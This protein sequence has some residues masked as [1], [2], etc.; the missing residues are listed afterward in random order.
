MQTSKTGNTLWSIHDKIHF[1]H[2]HSMPYPSIKHKTEVGSGQSINCLENGI[3]FFLQAKIVH[4][5]YSFF[6][7]S[8]HVELVLSSFYQFWVSTIYLPNSFQTLVLVSFQ[9]INFV[10]RIEPQFWIIFHGDWVFFLETADA[11]IFLQPIHQSESLK[12]DDVA[13]QLAVKERNS[14]IKVES[15]SGF[16]RLLPKIKSTALSL[17]LKP[18]EA[19]EVRNFPD[20]E[21]RLE[22]TD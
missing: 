13:S 16:A 15:V 2:V 1:K 7:A 14:E 3:T 19:S 10:S 11:D 22:T 12:F 20:L 18:T 4:F 8:H 9:R 5:C 6:Y 21:A 17:I